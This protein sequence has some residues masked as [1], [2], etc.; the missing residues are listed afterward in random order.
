VE[1]AGKQPATGHQKTGPRRQCATVTS[2]QSLPRGQ[3]LPQHTTGRF[4]DVARRPLLAPG[5]AR[6]TEPGRGRLQP[7]T[8][9]GRGSLQPPAASRCSARSSLRAPSRG[10]PP[11]WA[12]G[13]HYLLDVRDRS[14]T[15]RVLA[16]RAREAVTPVRES[17]C[18]RA[19]T[20]L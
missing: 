7:A 19:P 10:D 11:R 17:A 5:R 8:R 20:N 4:P 15:L 3:S 16:V 1:R 12:F 13:S 2:A 6:Y 9:P 14:A 18:R